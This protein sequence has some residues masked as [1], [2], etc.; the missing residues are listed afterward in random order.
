M[1][2][3]GRLTD[4]PYSPM[5]PPQEQVIPIPA[6]MLNDSLSPFVIGVARA[7]IQK[8]CRTSRG[9]FELMPRH[10]IFKDHPIRQVDEPSSACTELSSLG[11]SV[12]ELTDGNLSWVDKA[13]A[14]VE[15]SD[16]ATC[17]PLPMS[18][19]CRTHTLRFSGFAPSFNL[20]DDADL[21]SMKFTVR[22]R[23]AGDLSIKD[24]KIQPRSDGSALGTDLAGE[25]VVPQEWVTAEY[26]LATFPSAED[27]NDLLQVI[28]IQYEQEEWDSDWLDPL[29]YDFVFSASGPTLTLDVTYTGPGSG[30]PRGY[31]DITSRGTL[32]LTASGGGGGLSTSA[33]ATGSIDNGFE[34][35]SA[36]MDVD[37]MIMPG[38]DHPVA[39]NESSQ[40]VV[41]LFTAGVGSY[42]LERLA[43]GAVTS[44]LGYTVL[45]SYSGSYV[46]AVP[47][48]ASIEVDSVKMRVCYDSDSSTIY[49]GASAIGYGELEGAEEFSAVYGRSV[50]DVDANDIL[51]AK[52]NDWDGP[53]W[54]GVFEPDNWSVWNYGQYFFYA[55]ELNGVFFKRIGE[56]EVQGLYRDYNFSG[57]ISADGVGIS[58]RD[59]READDTLTVTT[60]HNDS[61]PTSEIND[62]GEFEIRFQVDDRGDPHNSTLEFTWSD[63]E[64]W[65]ASKYVAFRMLPAGNYPD[66]FLTDYKVEIK[67]GATEGAAS[68]EEIDTKQYRH[69]DWRTQAY[70]GT[71]WQGNTAEWIAF[72]RTFGTATSTDLV[73]GIRVRLRGEVNQNNNAGSLSMLVGK[74]ILGGAYL[75][76]GTTDKRIWDTTLTRNSIEYASRYKVISTDDISTGSVVRFASTD[77]VG[78]K[79]TSWSTYGGQFVELISQG[80]DQSP[81]V[82]DTDEDS[83]DVVIQFLRKDSGGVWRLLGEKAN[84]GAQKFTD[85]YEEHELSSLTEIDDFES[86]DTSG[87]LFGIV[88]D[89]TTGAAWKGANVYAGTNGKIYFSRS[90]DFRDVLWDGIVETNDVSGDK[91]GARTDVLADNISD[92]AIVL[93][94]AENL[95]AFT[96]NECY[97]FVAGDTPASASFPRKIDGARGA[98]GTKAATLF[99]DRALCASKDGLWLI[100][101]NTDYGVD[102]DELIELTADV[103]DS[104]A[105]LLGESPGTVVTRTLLG[106]IFVFNQS[107]ALIKLKDSGFVRVEWADGR[108]VSDVATSPRFG[109]AILWSTG[110]LSTVGSFSTDGG[111]DLTGSNGAGVEW[112]YQTG[113]S[114]SE[115]L[116][117]RLQLTFKGEIEIEVNGDTLS[118]SQSFQSATIRSLDVSAKKFATNIRTSGQVSSVKL[119]GTGTSI[120]ERLFLVMVSRTARRGV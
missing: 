70:D 49:S 59:W 26:D 29:N 45:S 56:D 99:A 80:T 40:R 75:C 11:A 98:L 19:I 96:A 66:F 8:N 85:S 53:Q 83:P 100:R 103:R 118:N 87:S 12:S 15:N 111:S 71:E 69:G 107:R 9:R 61:S 67:V 68:W 79:V 109:M 46:F 94:P 1:A 112:E 5:Q 86:G 39:F 28:D 34:T 120:V 21:T 110:E 47:A 106:D 7:A 43:T 119:S 17:G 113:T 57:T 73:F 41:V 50:F 95:Y 92:P 4:R 81:F 22:H 74:I 37:T 93:V 33:T 24:C 65:S 76:A 105:W 38:T 13:D 108:E 31:F 51:S 72:G 48:A 32:T 44:G 23:S 91:T 16:G 116:L 114:Q 18:G 117:T 89:I 84:N 97:V 102:P 88:K 2:G 60:D 104:W 27:V 54:S 30:P 101:K 20:P 36:S 35:S 78:G 77:T 52:T 115:L 62:E 25:D 64:D 14:V 63:G 6:A 10:R 82:R 3:S 58:L 42:T 90:Q 55:S